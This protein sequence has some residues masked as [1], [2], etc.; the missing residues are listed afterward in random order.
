LNYFNNP[1]KNYFQ[2]VPENLCLSVFEGLKFVAT[3]AKNKIK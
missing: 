3:V 2:G 1:F